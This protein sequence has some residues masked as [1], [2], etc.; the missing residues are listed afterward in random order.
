[1]RKQEG[2][3][4]IEL[5]IVIVILGILAAYAIPKYMSLDL[6][7]RKSVVR[8]LE[9]S[10]RAASDMVHAIAIAQ[11]ATTSVNI[12]STNVTI[13]TAKYPTPDTAGI[14]TALSDYT[15][16]NV[17]PNANNVTFQKNDAVNAALCLA[18]YNSDGNN[19]PTIGSLGTGTS[20]TTNCK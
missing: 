4:L 20:D 9:G 8:G 16:F 6:Q 12:G 2:F 11:G 5:I 18:Y 10:I 1:M 15:G 3:T 14:A 13:G 19:T 17:V 7:A